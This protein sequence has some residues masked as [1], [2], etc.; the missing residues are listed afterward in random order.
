VTDLQVYFLAV[1]I[2]SVPVTI[3]AL[4]LVLRGYDVTL[5]IRRRRVPRRRDED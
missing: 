5:V 4:F 1:L 2:G 3:V